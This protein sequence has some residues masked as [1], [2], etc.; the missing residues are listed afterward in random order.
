MR[1]FIA[2]V[3]T[4]ALAVGAAQA[5]PGNADARGNGQADREPR[6][7]QMQRGNP[8]GNGNA[9]KPEGQVSQPGRA[10]DRAE[11]NRANR[12]G[13][14]DRRPAAIA[15]DVVRDD[16]NTRSGNRDVRAVRGD[17]GVQAKRTTNADRE[18]EDVAAV[19]SI[20][21][22]DDNRADYSERNQRRVFDYDVNR[23]TIDGCPPGL[24]RKNSG[25][26]PPGFARR[27]DSAL[28]NAY[29]RPD[30]FGYEQYANGRYYYDDGY[31]YRVGSNDNILGF[32]P[33]LGGAL[34]IGTSWPSY[35]EREP[36]PIYYQDYYNL[37]SPRNYAY[38]DDVIYR[39]DPRTSTITSIAALL[40]GD[41]FTVGETM[42]PGY[43]VYNVPYVYRDEYYDRPDAHYRYADGYVYEVDPVTQ[44]IS[45]A[46]E[47]L[48]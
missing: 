43:D 16:R 3:A 18:R 15:R 39:L 42:P 36:V 10:N 5:Q 27:A 33:L 46:I 21:Y 34:G 47:L 38:A 7:E 14:A 45:S 13:D 6:S 2:G 20:A 8:G 23:G 25:C 17:G 1:K 24:A 11:A 19:Q 22:G 30:F 32:L 40:T 9:D 4:L 41:Q 48:A 12:N 28:G 26:S 37:G 44:V 35:Y 29:F 31:L